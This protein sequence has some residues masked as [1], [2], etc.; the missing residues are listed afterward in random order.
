PLNS[1][2]WNDHQ[3][4]H[5]R[6]Y[7]SGKLYQHPI[8]YAT[9]QD[10]SDTLPMNSNADWIAGASNLAP[11]TSCGSGTPACKVNVNDSDHSYFG[12]WTGSAQQNRN[13]AWQ[14]F[15][16]GN[17]V[18]FMDPYVLYYP[19]EGRN[20]CPSPNNGIC[21]GPDPRWNNFRDNLGYILRYSRKLNLANVTPRSSLCSTSRCLAQTPSVG[22]EYLV[23]SPFGGSFTVDLS[24]MSSARMLNVEWL[25]PS[26][27]A[28]IMA[29]PIPAGSSSRLFTPP[30]SGDAV[31]Y[32]VD[33]AGHAG[34]VFLPTSYHVKGLAAGAYSYRVRAADA[35]GNLGPY[36]NVAGA[37]IQP[38]DTEPPAAPGGLT[39]TPGTGQITLSWTAATD[40]VAVTG[41]LVERCQGVGCT[42]F[43][44]VAAPAGT[45]T[46]FGDSGLAAS[47]SYTY[48]VR[49]T[50]AAGNPGPYSNT[51]T[52]TT[53]PAPTGISLVQH[54]S[55]DAGAT[56]S[57]SLPFASNNTAGNWIAVAVRSWPSSQALTVTDTRG[58]TYRKAIQLNETVDGMALALFY[59]EN[60]AGGSNA[61]TVAKSGT[62]GTLRFAILEYSGVALANSLDKTA[63]AQGT[64]TT[65]SSGTVT[66]TSSGDLVIGVLAT[67]N[68]RTY[69]AGSGYLIEERVPGA[70]ST[71]LVV[72]D[73]TQTTAAPLSA[74]VTLNAS[75]VWGAVVAAF[76]AA[77]SGPVPTISVAANSVGTAPASATDEVAR[78]GVA[79]AHGAANDSAA[80]SSGGSEVFHD[81]TLISGLNRPAGIEFLPNGDMLI[82]GRGGEIWR[83]PAGTTR[84][85]ATPFLSLTNIDKD[86]EQ[87]LMDLA[88][89]PDFATNR[90]YYVFYTLGVPNRNRV[91]RFTA[92]ADY[93]GT[94][95][96]SELVLYQDPED[97][98]GEHHGGSLHFA[99][100]GKL[101]ITTGKPSNGLYYDSPSGKLVVG[102]FIYRGRQFPAQYVG[103][104]FFAD[105]AQNRIRRLTFAADGTVNGVFSFFEPPSGGLDG[106]HGDIVYLTQGSDGVLY[107]VDSGQSDTTQTTGVSRIR[108]IRYISNNLPPTSVVSA[109]V[110]A[111]PAPLAI[112]FSS[113]GSVDPEDVPL[114][115][116]WDFGD[117][118]TSVEPNP[119]HTYA[120]RGPYVARLT[121][122]DGNA[123]TESNPLAIAVGATPVATILNPV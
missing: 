97:A 23:Y 86:S 70:P 35:A 16:N 6:S 111:G 31:L 94:F 55:R 82:L 74:G 101:F 39:T 14:N 120:D 102:G 8:G 65:P 18:M 79:G 27:G 90:H 83:A 117:G 98:A 85:A 59:A 84:T 34:S 62:G 81:E 48:R 66:P 119:A 41:Y 63:A 105:S 3:V 123:N 38:P 45:G 5:I 13:F 89:D 10:L 76:R 7:E 93:S 52:A 71:K 107:Y 51:T 92:T 73:R 25:N 33:A 49:A 68:S 58:N 61:V 26:T 37:T 20:P 44:Q 118:S 96:G 11:T 115:Y 46:T 29:S 106:S 28:T 103:S 116:L 57:S 67:A 78:A 104:Y 9:L 100:D 42:T 77:P 122:S 43:T 32:L 17:Q 15:T 113:G 21:A 75:D 110:T 121:V 99:D 36:S 69:T 114:T 40:N 1:N 109:S 80:N 50:D 56:A 64:G 19:R 24:A 87:G 22:A 47:T 88:L 30:F 60:I 54:V 108:R 112:D 2:W 4:S 95:A 12:M 53:L 72:E 91:S